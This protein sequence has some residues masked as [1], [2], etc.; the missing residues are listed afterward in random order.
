MQHMHN[1]KKVLV[2]GGTSGIGKEIA[3]SFAKSGA[4]V[5]IVGTNEGRATEAI[6]HMN[7][8][9]V[10][11]DQQF[12]YFIVD[13][14]D[15]EH[16]QQTMDAVIKQFGQIDVLVNNAGITRDTLLMRMKE[17]EWDAVISTNLKSIFNR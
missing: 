2:T 16:V 7:D 6:K 8:N 9:R 14:A 4:D 10:R 1:G 15:T 17:E 3:F 13:V 11:D 12:A 5:A